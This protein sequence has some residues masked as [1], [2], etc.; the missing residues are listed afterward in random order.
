MPR[1]SAHRLWA[2][3]IELFNAGRFFDCHEVWE[4]VWKRTDGAEKLFYQG[5]IQAA[6]AILHAQRGNPRGARSTWDKARAKLDPLPAE[7]MGIALG[8]L[9][10]AVAAFVACARAGHP[11]APPPQIRRL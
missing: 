3:G 1:R 2:E 9:R 4:E 8:E 10:D 5:M 6:V 7:H 11:P